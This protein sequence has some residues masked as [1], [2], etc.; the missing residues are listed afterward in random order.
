M[1]ILPLGFTGGLWLNDRYQLEY[2]ELNK[3]KERVSKALENAESD[4]L[5]LST[6]T[7]KSNTERFN[8]L[9]KYTFYFRKNGMIYT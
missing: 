5:N 9:N 3:Q 2:A 4:A 7:A 6:E 1:L 8:E